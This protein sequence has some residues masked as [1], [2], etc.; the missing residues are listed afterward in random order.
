MVTEKRV[1]SKHKSV[2]DG[3]STSG[4]SILARIIARHHLLQLRAE[5]AVPLS[6]PSGQADGQADE[7]NGGQTT[8]EEFN[9]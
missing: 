6:V 9:E 2:H 5:H 7:Q 3:M 8:E 4:L 1:N